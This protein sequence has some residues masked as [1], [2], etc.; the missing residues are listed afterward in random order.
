[1]GISFGNEDGDF[2]YYVLWLNMD[3]ILCCKK[4]VGNF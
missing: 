1:M 2:L 3:V 4:I